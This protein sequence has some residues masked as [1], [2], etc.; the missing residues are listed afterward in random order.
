MK[1]FKYL[2]VLFFLCSLTSQEDV[3]GEIKKKFF[4]K[5]KILLE[6]RGS[7]EFNNDV[8]SLKNIESK[9]LIIDR[10]EL[11]DA[12]INEI[13]TR[14][15]LESKAIDQIKAAFFASQPNIYKD[16]E[17]SLN[18][19]NLNQ[20][21][22]NAIFT[23]YIGCCFRQDN[24]INYIIMRLSVNTQIYEKKEVDKIEYIMLEYCPPTDRSDRSRQWQCIN[25]NNHKRRLCSEDPDCVFIKK[26]LGGSMKKTF[27]KRRP[28][29]YAEKLKASNLV[30]AYSGEMFNLMI[31][32][33]QKET[34]K[35]EENLVI[36]SVFTTGQ[37]FIN[38]TYSV[39]AEITNYG[40][41]EI[42]KDGS[43]KSHVIFN[44]ECE[45]L[46]IR[47]FFDFTKKCKFNPT[48]VERENEYLIADENG[49]S[50]CIKLKE[51]RK[52]KKN[53]KMEI[54]TDGSMT[55]KSAGG[56]LFYA[57]P[58][59]KGKGPFTVGVT[60]NFELQIIDSQKVSVWK[61]NPAFIHDVQEI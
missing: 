34:I 13:R 15:N 26:P 46:T 22:D 24:M 47:S 29:N 43:S 27:Y 6:K 38:G 59:I 14:Y 48:C 45:N 25:S 10:V 52:E 39:Q 49:K 41:I 2:L 16:F 21:L 51:L 54:Y 18:S 32:D 55:I 30:R 7:Y 61:S 58:N 31:E 60:R 3:A 42:R 50:S 36:Q 37:V 9:S 1:V 20:I 19:A 35:T 5:I 44:K 57:K 17:F 53:I 28:L 23:E 33:V 11:N 4:S 40:D 12:K 56:I 8:L